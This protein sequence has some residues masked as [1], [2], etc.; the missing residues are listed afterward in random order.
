M[1]IKM[2]QA[3]FR[4]QLKHHRSE[5]EI[6]IA[7]STKG[8]V[9][10]FTDYEGSS[11]NLVL[12]DGGEL[13]QFKEAAKEASLGY[14]RTSRSVIGFHDGLTVLSVSMSN[15]G[16]PFEEYIKFTFT[17]ADPEKTWDSIEICACLDITNVNYFFKML[18]QAHSASKGDTYLEDNELLRKVRNLIM[19]QPDQNDLCETTNELSDEAVVWIDREDLLKDI[20]ALVESNHGN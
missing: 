5:T 18:S 11:A 1:Q 8:V 10:T 19:Q 14:E 6:A 13:E 3:T 4:T 7:S 16:D 12:A 2:N 15:Y 9:L 20:E 17:Q